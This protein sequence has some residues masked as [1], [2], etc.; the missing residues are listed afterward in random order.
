MATSAGEIEVKLTLNADDFK[1]GLQQGKTDTENFQSVLSGLG[2]TLLAVFSFTEVA[3][4][5]R[6][7]LT[8][9][10]ENELAVARLVN[11][12]NNQGIASQK[13]VNHL[14]S[15]ASALSDV[16]GESDT[17]IINAETL[18]TTFGVQGETMK[19]V[20]TAALNLSAAT[21][22][23]LQRAVMLL[24]KAYEGETGTLSRYGV[25]VNSHL[26]LN[27]RFAAVMDQV[28][29]RFGGAAQAQADTY[30]GKVKQLGNAFNKLEEEVGKFL[31]GPGGSLLSWITSIVRELT[32][33]MG[34]VNNATSGW[35]AF[36]LIIGSLVLHSFEMLAST[37]LTLLGAFTK[38]MSNL[39]V[40]GAAFSGFSTSIKSA[41]TAL[42]QQ[43]SLLNLTLQATLTNE[44]KKQ[45]AIEQTK[46]ITIQSIDAENLYM[47]DKLAEEVKLRQKV[48]A[49][50]KAAH[51][52]FYKSFIVTEGDMWGFATEQSNNF[53]K[54]FGD[55]LAASIIEG[56]NFGE[57][58]RNVFKQMAEAII[59]YIIQM[60]AKLLV[61]LALES[62]TGTGPAGGAAL[63]A[64]G[65][66]FADGGV[67]NE[68]SIIT[69]LRSG[70]KI[71][72]GENGPE[73]VSPMGSGLHTAS[74]MG[75]LPG[76]GG[77]GGGGGNIT[78]NISGQFIDGD[79]N[80]WNK[81]MR[82]KIIP[83]IRRF[84]MVSATGPFNRTRGVV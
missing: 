15:L 28:N 59:S 58:M 25:V 81:L 70:R 68:P 39:P 73:L 44:T 83:E 33:F 67:I 77:G 54:G 6:Q 69:G 8:A 9:Y 27:K 57:S 16:S 4:F 37:I 45:A 38:L 62:A 49:D 40:I 43:F 55:S 41:N 52:D 42:N 47:K 65:G 51:E 84:T 14:E 76:S 26:D 7:S 79:A 19:Q 12:L 71:L 60:I 23:D 72:A 34:V 29:T 17:A 63:S 30:S 10:G 24:G 80:S 78:I 50:N 22:I 48:F 11:A 32:S 61:L 2:K 1:K 75:G 82:E 5:F 74:E 46:K 35:S 64:L 66:A 20:T 18:L 13:V 21:G 3:N 36:A 56:K 31:S 53:F